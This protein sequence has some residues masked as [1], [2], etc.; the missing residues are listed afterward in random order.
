MDLIVDAN[1]LFA[2]LI[3]DGGTSGMMFRNE[4]NLYAPEFLLEELTKH[5]QTILDKTHRSPDEFER[6]INVFSRRIIFL[7]KDEFDKYIT[8]G[9]EISPDPDDS[10]YFALALLL[11]ADLWS[12]EKRLKNQNK[13]K[14]WSTGDLIDKFL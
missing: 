1:I 11:E 10:M 12:N 9:E 8:R 7:P 13:I 3:K 5:E 2:A 4:L 14:I 6:L